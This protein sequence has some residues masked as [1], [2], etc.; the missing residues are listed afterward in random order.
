MT[1]NKKAAW[2]GGSEEGEGVDIINRLIQIIT[3]SKISGNQNAVLDRVI[4]RLEVTPPSGSLALPGQR[5]LN[6]G[7]LRDRVLNSSFGRE[8][9]A[10][11]LRLVLHADGVNC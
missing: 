8:N 9:I 3:D 1:I 6:I 2:Q 10:L 7:I 11:A 5:V 4:G